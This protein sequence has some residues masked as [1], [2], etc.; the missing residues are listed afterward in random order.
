MPQGVPGVKSPPSR[1]TVPRSSNAARL[2]GYDIFLSFALGLNALGLSGAKAENVQ[3]MESAKCIPV[4]R[5][6]RCRTHL[7]RAIR[8]RGQDRALTRGGTQG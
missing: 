6:F 5:A 1:I 8:T 3:L 4:Q 2:F 7:P